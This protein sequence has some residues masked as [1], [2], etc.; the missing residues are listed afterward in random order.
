MGTTMALRLKA[1]TKEW[2]GHPVSPGSD[3]RDRPT[4][5]TGGGTAEKIEA[6]ITATETMI[7]GH[8]P[9]IRS[10]R[11][12]VLFVQMYSIAMICNTRVTFF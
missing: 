1:T 2:G 9:R 4:S 3:T 5:T 10:V 7:E 12:K 8:Q 6:R 11:S